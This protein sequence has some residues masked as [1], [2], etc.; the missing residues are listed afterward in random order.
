ML[1]F[2]KA[3]VVPHIYIYCPLLLS[4]GGLGHMHTDAA[5]SISQLKT[6]AAQGV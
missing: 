3:T 5:V 1:V 2:Q 4:L 6:V